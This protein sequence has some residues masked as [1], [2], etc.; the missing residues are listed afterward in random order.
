M[1][2]QE[3]VAA[4]QTWSGESATY[5][6]PGSGDAW[7]ADAARQ[8]QSGTQ[9]LVGANE[10]TPSP[11]VAEL[12]GLSEG[13]AVVVRQRVM[14]LDGRPVELTDSYYPA[15][16]AHGTRLAEQRKI[17]GGAVTVLAQLGFPIVGVSERV[18]VDLPSAD[19]A[20]ALELADGEPVL[21]LTRISLAAGGRPVEVGI[22][23]MPRG[24]CLRYE[25]KVG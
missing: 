1:G 9:Q 18:T 22:M 4:G 11:A 20:Q 5:V 8:G 24:A 15:T 14:H 21:I 23:T 25:M 13:E 12:L 16:I 7:A 10:A 19:V 3:R 17:P 2:S 6:T